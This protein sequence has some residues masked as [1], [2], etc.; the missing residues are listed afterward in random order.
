MKFVLLET[1]KYH[2]KFFS[3]YTEGEDPAT[4]WNGTIA[5][6]VLGYA[7]SIEEAQTKLYG[8]SFQRDSK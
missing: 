2:T 6:I 4:L 1:I 5:Y 7:D 3:T 8:R